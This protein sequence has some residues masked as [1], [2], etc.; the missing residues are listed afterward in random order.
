MVFKIDDRFL[1]AE[2]GKENTLRDFEADANLLDNFN[3]F[4]ARLLR[5]WT[6]KFI[7]LFGQASR[8]PSSSSSA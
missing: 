3:M 4:A 7:D 6:D 2:N 8:R 1:L 5:W